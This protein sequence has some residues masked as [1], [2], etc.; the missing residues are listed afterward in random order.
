MTFDKTRTLRSCTLHADSFIRSSEA[1][2]QICSLRYW[3]S[4]GATFNS[5]DCDDYEKDTKN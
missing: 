5:D 4:L 3:P 2:S 1:L